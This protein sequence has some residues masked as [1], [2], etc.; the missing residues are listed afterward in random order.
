MRL[1]RPVL[2]GGL[3]AG[4]LDIV[5]AFI[6]YGPLTYKLAPTAVLQSVAA[7]WLGE[8]AASAGGVMTAL[9]GLV[10]HFTLATVMAAVF[11]GC[12]ARWPTL[13]RRP[14][15]WGFI[16]GL[17][18]Y[19]V[20]TYL[21]VPLSAAHQSQHFVTNLQDLAARLQVS[22]GSVRPRNPGLLLGTLFTH[23]V[24]VGIPIALVNNR[25]ANREHVV[26]SRPIRRNGAW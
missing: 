1:L 4:A 16:Y 22:F 19:V 10:T 3:I 15:M 25:L 2:I 26:Q 5:Y 6:V 20:M 17:G 12:A 14:L 8:D 7:G 23:T 18:V 9:L 11:V 13:K 24:L 21:V